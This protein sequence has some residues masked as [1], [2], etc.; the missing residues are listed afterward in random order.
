MERLPHEIIGHIADYL[1]SKEKSECAI[2]CRAWHAEFARALYRTIRLRTRWQFRALLRTCRESQLGHLVRELNLNRLGISRDEFEVLPTLCS[3]LEEFAFHNYLWKRIGYSNEAI[4]D[5][6]SLR[7]VRLND[8]TLTLFFLLHMGRQL[9]HLDLSQYPVAPHYQGRLL[10]LMLMMARN[11]THLTLSG[12]SYYVDDSRMMQLSTDNLRELHT[13][14]PSLQYLSITNVNFLPIAN[15]DEEASEQHGCHPQWSMRTLKLESFQF[16]HPRWIKYLA[17]KYPG[18]ITI[19]W[20]LRTPTAIHPQPLLDRLQETK[21]ALMYIPRYCQQLTSF[22]MRNIEEAFWP[23]H[24]FLDQVHPLETLHLMFL[25]MLPDR[26]G[27]TKEDFEAMVRQHATTLRVLHMPIWYDAPIPDLFASLGRCQHLVEL[28]LASDDYRSFF[29]LE[30]D[31]DLLFSHCQHLR[32]LTLVRGAVILPPWEDD[33]DDD[34]NDGGL[35]HSHRPYPSLT[36]LSFTLMRLSPDIF[37]YLSSRCLHLRDLRL[38]NCSWVARGPYLSIDMP[39]HT[40]DTLK[41]EQVHRM[42]DNGMFHIGYEATIVKVTLLDKIRKTEE[43][44]GRFIGEEA[45]SRWYHLHV[46]EQLSRTPLALGRLQPKELAELE[47]YRD[48]IIPATLP[49]RST[50]HSRRKEWM[51]DVPYGYVF[52]RCKSIKQLTMDIVNIRY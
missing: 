45:L 8:P 27:M 42:R 12:E 5:Y 28:E 1:S 49:Q 26:R 21:E 36:Q 10:I 31:L 44:K 52:I 2:V 14:C 23:G 40:F 13:I 7:R 9:T 4:R 20:Q 29:S 35:R 25:T 38:R 30:M 19:D 15:D 18:L 3:N 48:M 22:R 16:Q 6:K 34:D 51:Y 46:V 33:D 37:S 43:R 47:I 17:R 50:P 24:S 32:I 39:N 41:I 11:L